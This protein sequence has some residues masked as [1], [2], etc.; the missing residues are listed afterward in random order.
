[1]LARLAAPRLT[2]LLFR[3]Q[4]QIRTMASS[5]R[6]Y[7]FL[8]IVPDKP[9]MHTKRL[10]VRPLHFKN[11]GPNVESGAWKMGGALLNSVPE[12]DDATNFDFMGS[13]F[14]CLAESKE[15]VLKQV[16]EDVYATSGAQIYPFK[17][18][19]RNP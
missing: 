7:E 1:M 12:D 17:C 15:A 18:A 2:S 16:K 4:R 11:M 5:A 13:T 19:F 10:E 14:V 6:T 9:G 8:V 3:P